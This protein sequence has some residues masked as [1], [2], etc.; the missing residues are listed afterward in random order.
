[1]ALAVAALTADGPTTITGWESV[2]TSYPGFGED[3]LGCA[4]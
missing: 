4:S 1:M 2:A 3:L